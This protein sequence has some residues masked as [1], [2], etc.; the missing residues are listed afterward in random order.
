WLG[1]FVLWLVSAII[2]LLLQRSVLEHWKITNPAALWIT[3]G[4]V[5]LS[6][7]LPLFSGVLQGQ[8]NFL[9]LGWTMILNGVGRLSVAVFA[10]LVLGGLAAGM[11]TGTLLGLLVTV[12]IAIWQT[13]SLW[14]GPAQPFDWRSLLRQV[15]PL[16]LGAGAFQF[17]FTA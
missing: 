1:T 15:T 7:W 14:L 17:L 3:L 4:V 12:G 8:Q 2:V 11:L 9:W 13:R 10:V 16:L 6:L 5:L